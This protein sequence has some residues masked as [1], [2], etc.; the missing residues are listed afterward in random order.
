MHTKLA[1]WMKRVGDTGE[2]GDVI[3]DR[4]M[5]GSI[6]GQIHPQNDKEFDQLRALRND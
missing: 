6:G 2:N 4:Y 5:P 1:A 3:N